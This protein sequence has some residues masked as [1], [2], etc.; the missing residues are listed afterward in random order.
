MGVLLKFLLTAFVILVVWWVVKFRAR[1]DVLKAAVAAAKKAAEDG[2][3]RSGV[4]K[5]QSAPVKLVPC[6]KCG[7]YNA[8]GKSCS[9][10]G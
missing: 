7:A 9:C 10:G 2:Q 6:P 3:Q 4:S 5:P 8:E 1:V